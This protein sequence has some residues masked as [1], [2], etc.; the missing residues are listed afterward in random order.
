MLVLTEIT[1]LKCITARCACSENL[2][3]FTLHISSVVTFLT[4]LLS[5][6]SSSFLLLILLPYMLMMKSV[7]FHAEEFIPTWRW[8]AVGDNELPR[9]VSSSLCSLLTLNVTQDDQRFWAMKQQKTIQSMYEIKSRH[10]VYCFFSKL[11]LFVY[12]SFWKCI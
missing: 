10:C 7:A 6:S 12:T 3:P 8:P 11:R 1:S 9:L 5:S 4:S 2:L